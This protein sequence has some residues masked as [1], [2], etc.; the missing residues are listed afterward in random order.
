MGMTYPRA[1]DSETSSAL[2]QKLRKT[3]PLNLLPPHMKNFER[4][5]AGTHAA[6]TAR[7]IRE[8]AERYGF[9]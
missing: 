9:A 8:V 5:L 3:E 6:N 2:D 4:Q 1:Y 7:V